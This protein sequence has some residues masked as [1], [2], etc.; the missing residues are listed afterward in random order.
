MNV[1]GHTQQAFISVGMGMGWSKYKHFQEG[2]LPGTP[3]KP[4]L[5]DCCVDLEAV[6]FVIWLHQGWYL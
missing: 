1:Y 4:A 3:Q 2:V 5:R 6:G